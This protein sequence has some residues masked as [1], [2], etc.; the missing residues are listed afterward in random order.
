VFQKGVL[1]CAGDGCVLVCTYVS[2]ERLR[3]IPLTAV[4]EEAKAIRQLHGD[5]QVSNIL[6]NLCPCSWAA[7]WSLLSPQ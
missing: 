3:G 5:E 7:G 1:A 2:C 4:S 6:A